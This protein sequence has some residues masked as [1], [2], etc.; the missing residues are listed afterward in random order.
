MRSLFI[1]DPSDMDARV[2][3]GV[4]LCSQEFLKIV[5]AASNSVDYLEVKIC[6]QL[7]WR[8]RRKLSLGAYLWYNPNE[9]RA[10]LIAKKIEYKPT[11]IFLNKSELIRLTPLLRSV[12]PESQIGLMSHG[13]QSGDDLYEVSGARGARNKGLRRFIA[14]LKIGQDLVTES[15]FRHR[16]VDFVCVMSEEES[17]LER[18]LGSKN[19]VVLPRTITNRTLS[20]KPIVG[21]IGF[22][23]TLNHTPNK[24]ALDLIC[25]EIAK[26]SM[27]EKINVELRL[28]GKPESEGL[29]LASNYNF[30][31]YLGA[32]NDGDLESEVSSWNL[33]LNPIFWLSRGASMKL[34]QAISFGI[35]FVTTQSGKRG[36]VLEGAEFLITSDNPQ[37][38]V[39]RVVELMNDDQNI[40]A[41]ALVENIQINSPTIQSLAYL[42]AGTL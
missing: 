10:K 17:V 22:V 25:E 16:Y 11:H 20:W 3:G 21:R 7:F 12:F 37:D 2:V 29:R 38:F 26:K 24:V 35:P 31:K 27:L 6:R 18:W 39:A 5:Q 36:Y 28:V 41:K 1:F 40:K 33:F 30:V 15:W 23:G 4:Q 32:L 19:T 9:V 42:I 34:G 13:N 8:L 14:T